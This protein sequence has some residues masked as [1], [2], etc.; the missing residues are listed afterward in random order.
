MKYQNGKVIL[1]KGKDNYPDRDLVIKAYHFAG[2]AYETKMNFHVHFKDDMMHY[3]NWLISDTKEP[4]ERN[5]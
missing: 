1:P 3:I 5:K 4:Y 2:G